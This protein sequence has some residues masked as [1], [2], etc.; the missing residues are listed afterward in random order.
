M[1]AM[2]LNHFQQV[3]NNPLTLVDTP[4]PEA[5]AGQVRIHVE[6]CG[7]CHTDLHTVEGEI[8]PPKMPIIPGHQVVGVVD[9][10]GED[11]THPTLGSR[12]GVPWLYDVCGECTFCL[13]GN[14]NLCPEARFTGFHID[15]GYAEYML[16]EA[17]YAL[18]IPKGLTSAYAAPLLCAGIIGYRSLKQADLEPGERLGLVGFG[19]IAHLA[20]QVARHWDCEIYV[21]TRSP[22]HRHHAL[23][24]GA[25]WVGGSEDTPP[26]TLDRAIIFA[27]AGELVPKMLAKLRPGGTLAINAIYMSPIPEMPYDL[28]Y[29]ERT[30]RS[31][32]NATYQDGVELLDLAMEIPIQATTQ[33]YALPDANRA[34]FDL[35]YSRFNG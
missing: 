13:S 19:A 9:Q 7:V 29:A 14:E 6:V 16:A 33:Q 21:F 28:I 23:E 11:V 20:I 4:L 27:P 3:E 30:L 10:L 17:K 2:Q 24:L 12:V 5:K 18:P 1:Q 32:A 34:L 26:N 8:L 31:V 15:G 22:D 35:K 25:A